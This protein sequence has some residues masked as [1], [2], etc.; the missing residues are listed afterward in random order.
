MVTNKPL[1]RM[2]SSSQIGFSPRTHSLKQ[3]SIW[4]AQLR[5]AELPEIFASYNDCFA[6]TK[7]GSISVESLEKLG[8]KRAVMRAADGKEIEDGPIIFGHAERSPIIMFDAL[9][10]KGICMVNARIKSFDVF[11]GFK[12]AFGGKLPP[13]SEDGTTTYVANGQLVQ[14]AP[15]GTREAPALR[16]IVEKFKREN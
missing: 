9:E 12:Q 15:T 5:E 11:E 7:T 16:L 13:A 14:I 1:P 8:W 6:A 2:A 10:G 3:R 4:E